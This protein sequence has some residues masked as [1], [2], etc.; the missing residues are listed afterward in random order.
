[1][2]NNSS[3]P[4]PPSSSA[5][6]VSDAACYNAFT[7]AA[8]SA[9]QT[10]EGEPPPPKKPCD[11]KDVI[12]VE[13]AGVLIKQYKLAF[14]MMGAP[15]FV[16]KPPEKGPRSISILGGAGAPKNPHN[17]LQ[18]VSFPR[19]NQ[20]IAK[21][22]VDVIPFAVQ[23]AEHVSLTIDRPDQSDIT[24][25]CASRTV[26][27]F[28]VYSKDR[29]TG[30][31]GIFKQFW[32]YGSPTNTYTIKV[33]SCGMRDSGP[34]VKSAEF[35]V[36]VF[37]GDQVKLM[38]RIPSMYKYSRERTAGIKAGLDKDKGLVAVDVDEDTKKRQY[39]DK[40]ASAKY[41]E[42][43][44]YEGG[45]KKTSSEVA[46]GGSKYTTKQS[47]D[48]SGG[49]DIDHP[50]EYET[51]ADNDVLDLQITINDTALPGL[52]DAQKIMEVIQKLK[53]GIKGLQDL[54]RDWVPQAG[55]KFEFE[56]ELFAGSIAATWGYRENSDY[57]VYYG[58][59]LE[60]SLTIIRISLILSFGIKIGPGLARVEG[61]IK[62]GKLLVSEKWEFNSPD[63]P[64]NPSFK[65][66]VDIP[67]IL[68]GR[69]EAS[70]LSMSIKE[71]VGVKSGFN[72]S[73]DIKLD[74]H[75]Q[76]SI[77]TKTKYVGLRA[78]VI[79]KENPFQ[80]EEGEEWFLMDEKTL[81]EGK[82]PL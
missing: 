69:A 27:E 70:L 23:D 15:M 31:G 71:E 65:Q 56:V 3:N 39:N 2:A 57:R 19:G 74:E 24:A 54:L 25:V 55:F 60:L 51:G 63:N 11:I 22:S 78:Y 12:L 45:T 16:D 38:L 66:V 80:A 29:P 4:P 58:F 64:V 41:S 72:V 37:L 32:T 10:C 30:I 40:N 18:V 81:W 82:L 26:K 75:Q 48:S 17:L 7:P 68:R 46:F 52:K 9:S 44:D 21:I 67:F 79:H 73:V 49:F 77:S 35:N 47:S 34:A 50:P 33:D 28:E 6:S 8:A 42:T 1:M 14:G 76:F 62:D 13:K 53:Q 43:I 36:E 61:G 20:K 5:H 59:D